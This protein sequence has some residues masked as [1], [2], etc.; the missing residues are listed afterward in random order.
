MKK[1]LVIGSTG[2]LGE[3]SMRFLEHSGD[4]AVGIDM[5]DS[6]FTHR[7]ITLRAASALDL[8]PC[9]KAVLSQ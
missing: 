6:P 1:V 5:Q 4:E 3:A 2:H 8:L 7:Q 9:L